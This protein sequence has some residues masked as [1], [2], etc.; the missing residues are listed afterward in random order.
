M[1]ART[2]KNRSERSPRILCANASALCIPQIKLRE[3]QM[4][5]VIADPCRGVCDTSCVDVCPV[6]CIHPAVDIEELREVRDSGGED[7]L[8]EKYG[9]DVQLYID[10]DE[11]ISCGACEPMCPVQAI[12]EEDEIPEKWEHYIEINAEFY[13]NR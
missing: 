2:Q 7:A 3:S 13:R 1:S 10:P 5:Y 8:V 6:D 11:C 12:F 4:I 9:P